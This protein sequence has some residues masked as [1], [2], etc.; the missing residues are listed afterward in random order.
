MLKKYISDEKLRD[1]HHQI[2]DFARKENGGISIVLVLK[3]VPKNS[4]HF[5]SF[6]VG[7][8]HYSLS[9]S[10]PQKFHKTW[11]CPE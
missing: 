11:E 5:L 8:L 9:R 3:V 7:I 6:L 4:K 1:N 2:K 10:F